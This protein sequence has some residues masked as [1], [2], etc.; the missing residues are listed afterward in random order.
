MHGKLSPMIP[1]ILFHR[2]DDGGRGGRCRCRADSSNISLSSVLPKSHDFLRQQLGMLAQHLPR[3]LHGSTSI[4]TRGQCLAICVQ[5]S[6]QVSQ[7]RPNIL[8]GVSVAKDYLRSRRP[9]EPLPK[10]SKNFKRSLP[11][12]PSNLEEQPLKIGKPIA[13]P[14]FARN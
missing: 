14:F 11:T 6:K 9:S 4:M 1:S 12:L 8:E 2:N 5:S 13:D 7:L 3:S 10:S